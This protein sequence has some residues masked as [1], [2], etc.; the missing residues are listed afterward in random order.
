MEKDWTE[1]VQDLVRLE[2]GEHT[3]TIKAEPTAAVNK[4]GRQVLRIETDKGILMTGSFAVMR[5]LK[6]ARNK[7]GSLAG[8]R[9]S[10]TVAG[11]GINRRYLNIKVVKK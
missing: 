2:E 11:T 1:L 3:L 5:E 8:A 9:L 4:W 10:F 7:Y 6:A